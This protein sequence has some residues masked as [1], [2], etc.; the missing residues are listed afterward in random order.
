MTTTVQAPPQAP[1]PAPKPVPPPERP[2]TRSWLFGFWAVVFVAFLAKSPGKMTFETKLGVAADPWQFLG[3]LGQLWHDRGGFGG[4]A[5]QYIGYL[6]PALPYYGLTDLLQIPTWLAERLWMSLIVAAAF[7]GALRLAERLGPGTR[8][9]R[10]LAAAVYALWP[11]YTIVIGS[12][13]AAALPGA[14]LPWVLLPLTSYT[15]TPRVAAARSALIIPFMGGVNA[16]STLAALLPALLYVLTRT[17]RRRRT[18][19]AWWLPGVLLATI[20]WYVPLLLLGA[21]GEDFMPYVESAQTTTGTMSATEMLRGGGN[22]TAY[23]HFGEP[24]L[25]AGWT[26][27]A[28]W[29]AVLGGAFAAALG[30]AGLARRDLPER[31]W[32]V[33]TVLTVTGVMLA[34]YAGALGAPFADPVQGWLDG[35]LRP[36]RNIYKFQPGLALALVFGLAQL[37]GVAVSTRGTRPLPGR[38]LLLWVAALAVLPGLCLPYANGDILQAGAFKKLPRHWEQ[39][40][41]WLEEHSPHTRAYVTPATAHGL[42]TWGSPV[43]QPLDVLAK[44]PWAQ[45]DYVPFGTPGNRR[46]TDAVEQ[47]LMSGGEV[48]GLAEFLARAGLYDVVVR[49]DLDPDQLGYVPPQTVKRTLEASGYRK[50]KSFGPQLTGGR[51][52]EDTPLQVAGFYPRQRA[53]EIYEPTGTKRPKDVALKPVS[54]TAQVSGG[55]EALLPLAGDARVKDRPAVLTGDNHPGIGTPPLQISGDGLRRADTRFGLVNSNTSYTYTANE[56]N[57][58]D[59]VQ[60]PGEKPEQILPTTGKGHQTTSVLRGAKS[61]TA[62]SSGNWLFH[63]PQF[64]PVGA[65]DGNPDTAWA[66]GTAGE[67]E[68]QWIKA[69]FKGTVDIPSS[70]ELT[71]LP[72]DATR[73][74]PTRVKVETDHGSASS[75]LQPNGKRQRIKAP[76]GAAHW[77]KLTITRAQTPRAG[78]SGA[79]FSEISIPHVQVTRLLKLPP[80]ADRTGTDSDL[81]SLHRGSDPGGLSP[82]SAEVGL[83]REF[84]TANSDDYDVRARALPV[85]GAELDRLLDEA[86]PGSRDRITA[87]ADSTAK[88][89][90]ALSARNLVD[91]N[92]STAWIAGDKPTIRLSWP[93]K[94]RIREIVL[95]PAGGISAAAQEI[96]ISSPDGAT[97]A[98]VDKNGQARFEPITTDRITLTVTKTKPL[99]VHNPL[100][101]RKLQLPVGLNE[102]YL[103]ALDEY[104]VP[105]PDPDQTFELPCGK[106]PMLAVD[107]T[108]H[109]TKAAGKVRDL[110]GRRP[111][112]VELCA[113]EAEDGSIELDAGSHTVETGDTGPLALTDVTLGS[114]D[115]GKAAAPASSGDAEGAAGAASDDASDDASTGASSG[116]PRDRESVAHDWKGDVRTVEVGDGP[117]SYL[118]T[119]ENANDGW[120]AT[121]NG[122]E[123]SPLRLDGWQQGFLVPA[124][125]EGTVKLEYEPSTWYT[126]GLIAGGAG[127]AVLLGCAFTRTRRGTPLGDQDEVPPPG[128]VLGTVALTLVTALVAGPYA[129]IVPALAV[130]ARFKPWV[131]VPVALAGMAGAGVL[132]AVGA[133]SAVGEGQGAFGHV[134]QA[135]ALLALAAALVTL[136]ARGHEGGHE[137]GY[138]PVGAPAAPVFGPRPPEFDP[139]GPEQPQRPA[140][141]PEPP[142]APLPPVPPGT[143]APPAGPPPEGAT[144]PLGTGRR[145]HQD[146]PKH[147]DR[148]DDRHDHQHDHRPKPDQ[149]EDRTP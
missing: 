147:E 44:S 104:R 95:A 68:G 60:E 4:I 24:W 12:T 36:F 75:F 136:P 49:N 17:G 105:A 110:T 101:D 137:R 107:G 97:S 90:T 41:D 142:T 139:P 67:P 63:L 96:R 11:A 125:E 7:W 31:R 1:A 33:L 78:L 62:S 79:G 115:D 30:L 48:P 42:Y 120:K 5:D 91:G 87:S 39:T 72:G 113:G 54:G 85:P 32:L 140:Y 129:L 80:D 55:P 117:A 99:T 71:P 133:G 83:H 43:D 108:L 124:G 148:R 6:F 47:A 58:P 123:L 65:F 132:A 92:L 94:K 8:N 10:L 103:P 73:A 46:A 9:T 112:D 88:T 28:S 14:V 56:K 134:A 127:I 86:A 77:L 40:A 22:W 144:P 15:A 74:A 52:P 64:E 18:L 13:S 122:K 66:E 27:A 29:L 50:V 53:V 121:L 111:I 19:L 76:Q 128:L 70:I 69:G 146:L 57:H 3:D 118:Q 143:P 93:K 119:H 130:L 100:A 82:V 102:V 38:R 126:A 34:G 23:L 51:I 141:P 26:V 25:P 116:A 114:G 98:G 89:G 109:A 145:G 149:G 61:V 20:W 35:W 84:A 45:R 135:L 21:Y 37:T 81:F 138:E 16:A 59:S 131:L 106:G 2:W